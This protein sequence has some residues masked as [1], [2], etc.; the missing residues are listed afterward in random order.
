MAVS[1]LRGTLA[2][3][4]RSRE[5][6]L[7]V[8]LSRAGERVCH[9]RGC[10][11]QAARARRPRGGRA[12]PPPMALDQLLLGLRVAP[13]D[14]PHELLGTVLVRVGEDSLHIE[15]IGIAREKGTVGPK[16]L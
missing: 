10:R 12:P 5:I 11:A 4:A 6:E 8:P 7:P 16:N 15:E 13:Q 2:P 1:N 14:A 9:G 3:R